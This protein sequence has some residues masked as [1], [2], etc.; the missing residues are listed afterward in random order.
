MQ[1]ATRTSIRPNVFLTYVNTDKFKVSTISI[2]VLCPLTQET[3]PKNALIPRVLRRGTLS[4]P[5]MKSLSEYLDEL[6]GGR[7]WAMVYATGTP[8]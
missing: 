2:N 5:D 8:I 4:L 7:K 3:A 6:Y 1:D